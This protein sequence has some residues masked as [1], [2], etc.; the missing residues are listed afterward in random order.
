ML[1]WKNSPDLAGKANC[2]ASRCEIESNSRLILSREESQHFLTI[3]DKFIDVVQED[4]QQM[5]HMVMIS[6]GEKNPP[7]RENK[8]WK[9]VEVCFM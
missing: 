1:R 8:Q 2:L 9:L 4:A 6:L 3:C 5:I 7:A